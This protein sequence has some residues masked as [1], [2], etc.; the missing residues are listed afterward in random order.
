MGGGETADD[1]GDQIL[2][3]ILYQGVGLDSSPLPVE[4]AL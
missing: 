3:Q 4:S 2:Y 1:E